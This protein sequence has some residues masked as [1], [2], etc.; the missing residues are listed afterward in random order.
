MDT[1]PESR[2]PRDSD[3][4]EYDA[5]RV[6]SRPLP[7]TRRTARLADGRSLSALAFTS[8]LPRAVFLHGAGLNA[9]SFDPAVLAV[10]APALSV[11]LPGHG[12]SDWRDD[13]DY[14]PETL[15]SDL[16]QPLDR[17]APEPVTLVGHSLGG[18]AA[19][20]L[21]ARFPDRFPQ[22]V[23]IDIVPTDSRV[24]A[25]ARVRDIGEFIRGQ[26]CF[27]SREE[28]VERAL[29]FGIGSDRQ[30]LRRGVTFNSR[31]R[32]DGQWE[33][34]HHLAQLDSMPVG[35][36]VPEVGALAHTLIRARQGI[37]E[38]ADLARWR[39]RFPDATLTELDGPHNLHEARPVEL[40][41]A[42]RGLIPCAR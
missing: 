22:V 20:V 4:L 23:V 1:P 11:D 17:W 39:R 40:G 36:G 16:A 2:G 27:A 24:S 10:G 31:E 38:A 26:R 21:G 13:A 42:L 14:R 3:F 30:A 12:H 5:R 9:H 32:S 15:A 25:A 8:N 34:I 29:A 19:L 33:W 18:L 41:A 37:L 6:G 7:L 35:H 28:M